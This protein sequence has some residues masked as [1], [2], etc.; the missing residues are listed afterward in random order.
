M[1]QLLT[2]IAGES[3]DLNGR[4][5]AVKGQVSPED[6]AGLRLLALLGTEWHILPEQVRQEARDLHAA[7]SGWL[8]RFFHEARAADGP[9]A[10]AEAVTGARA[11][12]HQFIGAAAMSP[13]MPGP[14]GPIV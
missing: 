6:P 14:A 5:S 7:L 3:E 12:L 11:I 2:R 9:A 10:H 8:V 1:N 13:L 4:L